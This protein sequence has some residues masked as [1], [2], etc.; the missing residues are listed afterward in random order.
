MLS[1]FVT[2]SRTRI[3]NPR[4]VV[5][6]TLYLLVITA[7]SL[8]SSSLFLSSVSPRKR[9]RGRESRC[10]MACGTDASSR[11]VARKKHLRLFFFFH[12]PSSLNTRP[13]FATAPRPK[14]RG[15][16]R[17]FFLDH[18]LRYTRAYKRFR[19][20]APGRC[21][22]KELLRFLP[23]YPYVVSVCLVWLISRTA[24]N[25][26]FVSNPFFFFFFFVEEICDC[27]VRRVCIARYTP[28]QKSWDNLYKLY[29]CVINTININY[30]I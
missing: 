20:R 2:T 5:P 25:L 18:V 17:E 23:L 12:L 9:G 4:Y 29:I 14:P 30:I 11:V 10:S 6:C 7:P 8:A 28:A 27:Y 19:F 13:S 21:R 1:R 3:I 16:A 24:V 26:F 15:T 22:R